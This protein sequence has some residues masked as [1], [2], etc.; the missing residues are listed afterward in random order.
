MIVGGGPALWDF[1]QQFM[2][3]VLFSISLEKQTVGSKVIHTT[4]V[5][6][7]PGM[8]NTDNFTI[9]DTLQKSGATSAQRFI[10][11]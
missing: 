9:A 4:E 3:S 2:Q 6:N 10:Y 11:G 7:Y 1:Q 8:P 5:E